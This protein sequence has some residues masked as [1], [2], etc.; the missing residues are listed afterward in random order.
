VTAEAIPTKNRTAC[1][2]V[3]CPQAGSTFLYRYEPPHHPGLPRWAAGNGPSMT[4]ERP[5]ESLSQQTQ[6]LGWWNC[7]GQHVASSFA[8]TKVIAVA[9]ASC[10]RPCELSSAYGEVT[11]RCATHAAK[12]DYRARMRFLESSTVRGDRNKGQISSTIG[13]IRRS[14]KHQPAI[15]LNSRRRWPRDQSRQADNQSAHAA[16]E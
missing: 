4:A 1:R 6:N 7:R 5:R 15:M 14:L 13:R 10:D 11:R 2:L 9:R 8:C 16:L 12:R 3:R